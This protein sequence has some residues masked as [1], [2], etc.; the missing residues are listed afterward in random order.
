MA[1]P[2]RLAETLELIESLDR[3]ERIDA[4][5]ALAD[6]FREVPERVARRPFDEAARV[7][8]C[9]S[10]AYVFAEPRADGERVALP[11]SVVY[12]PE[13]RGQALGVE[14]DGGVAGARVGGREGLERLEVRGGG[15]HRAPLAQLLQHRLGQRGPVVGVGARAQLVEQH[16]RAVVDALQHQAQLLDEGGEG[17]E[18]L[19]HALVVADDR[20]ALREHGQTCPR[21]GRHVAAGLGHQRE[22]A[23]GLEGHRLAARV[24]AGD[25]E[26]RA[27]GVDLDVH[28]DY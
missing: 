11:G 7:P 25:D 12:E 1:L 13:G 20:E 6:R 5:I 16:Q 23:Q 15:H 28:R 2:T 21:A 10:Q 9:E 24:G 27:L 17:R 22:Q 8:G 18:V 3:S 26:Q 19:G 14:L 4:L